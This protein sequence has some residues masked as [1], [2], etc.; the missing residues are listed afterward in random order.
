MHLSDNKTV[1]GNTMHSGCTPT[2]LSFLPQVTLHPTH[3][4]GSTR[5]R[6]QTLP[7]AQ[8]LALALAHN[9]LCLSRLTITSHRIC[10]WIIRSYRTI[11]YQ[12]RHSEIQNTSPPQARQHIGCCCSEQSPAFSQSSR[13]SPIHPHFHRKTNCFSHRGIK[14]THF[15]FFL[16]A[17]FSLLGAILLL[18]A[19]SSYTVLVKKCQSINYILLSLGNTNQKIPVGIVVNEGSGVLLMWAACVCMILSVIPYF[20][21]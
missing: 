7:L 19:S 15:T 14:K 20:I 6:H 8:V 10:S 2:V 16:S 18:I 5:A 11:L 17:V 13:A 4:L 21:R 9:S 3:L 12:K 1:L